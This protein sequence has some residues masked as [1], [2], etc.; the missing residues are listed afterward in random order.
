M[1][2]SKVSYHLK[3]LRDAGLGARVAARALELL[4]RGRGSRRPRPRRSS[5]A[6]SACTSAGRRS[7][8]STSP[9]RLPCSSTSQRT[10]L[11]TNPAR[12]ATRREAALSRTTSS[13]TR[14]TGGAPRAQRVARR[15]RGRRSR[16]RGEDGAIQYA[17]SS[18][19]RRVR[20]PWRPE[21]PTGRPLSRGTHPGGAAAVRAGEDGER[22]ALAAAPA[23][24]PRRDDARRLFERVGSGCGFPA[25]GLAGRHGGGDGRARRRAASRRTT[26]TPS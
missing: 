4:Q 5:L 26:T 3:V 2:Q 17:P 23:L 21:R 10:P 8:M 11:K 24:L 7:K 16:S 9:G 19:S 12:S 14:R 13:H 25:A 22:E 18:C 1:A 20:A 6:G 15:G